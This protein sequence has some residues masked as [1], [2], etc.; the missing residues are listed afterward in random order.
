M[1]E[2]FLLLLDAKL[3]FLPFEGENL[4]SSARKLKRIFL[5]LPLCWTAKSVGYLI[6]LDPICLEM[7]LYLIAFEL[8]LLR[9]K[10]TTENMKIDKEQS[11]KA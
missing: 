8:W 7:G 2:S 6:W 3:Y 11:N 9:L 1:E 4:H 10:I 5:K